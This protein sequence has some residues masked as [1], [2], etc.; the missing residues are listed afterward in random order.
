M[1]INSLEAHL[2]LIGH[3][4]RWAQIMCGLFYE[5]KF[6]RQAFIY[7]PEEKSLN[8]KLVDESNDNND[9]DMEDMSDVIESKK[10]TD[11]EEDSAQNELDHQNDSKIFENILNR[12]KTRFKALITLQGAI[13]SLKNLTIPQNDSYSIDQMRF[14]VQSTLSS[15]KESTYERYCSL[16]FTQHFLKSDISKA[17]NENDCLFFELHFKNQ[18]AQLHAQIVLNQDYPRIKPLFALNINWK[19]DR[20]FTNDE[21]VRE[22][23]REINFYREFYSVSLL[24][25]GGG[26]SSAAASS[27]HLLSRSTSKLFHDDKS[28]DLFSKQIN[29]LIVCFDIYL[30]SESYFLNN[31]EY[32]RLK[33]FPNTVRGRDRKRPYSYSVAK[34]LFVQRMKYDSIKDNK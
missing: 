12:L 1:G 28:Y 3:P 26:I 7:P 18:S 20:N 15:F 13:H 4:Y 31:F 16:N 10:E 34:D 19:K 6:D 30:E 25:E 8:G 33:L 5:N 32:Q 14:R 24:Q 23:E 27:S 22:M 17:I 2:K 29:H 9:N 21:A 11:E